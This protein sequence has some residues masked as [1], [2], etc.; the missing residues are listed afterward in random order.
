[1]REKRPDLP[2]VLLLIKNF[3]LNLASLCS[4][5]LSEFFFFGFL[6][7]LCHQR[8]Q[9]FFTFALFINPYGARLFTLASDLAD[10]PLSSSAD[11]HLEEV[12]K[13]IA[14]AL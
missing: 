13:L 4:A 9:L 8:F 7:M 12:S 3:P 1:V 10:F 5:A 11:P 6:Q 2:A 14:D